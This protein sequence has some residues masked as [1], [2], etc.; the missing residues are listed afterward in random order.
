MTQKGTGL[1]PSKRA[2]YHI[3][4]VQENTHIQTQICEGFWHHDMSANMWAKQSQSGPLIYQTLRCSR[5]NQLF[6]RLFCLWVYFAFGLFGTMLLWIEMLQIVFHGSILLENVFL[7]FSLSVYV[8][9]HGIASYIFWSFFFLSVWS[10]LCCFCYLF[11]LDLASS[12]RICLFFF[13][14]CADCA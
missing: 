9:L 12:S 3:L 8:W 14:V 2:S 1:L 10:L 11:A 5:H 7:C 13:Q 6:S 4:L